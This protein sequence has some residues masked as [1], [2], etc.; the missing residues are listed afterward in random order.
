MAR[1]SSAP[2][3]PVQWK[4]RALFLRCYRREAMTTQ[5]QEV[6]SRP[7]LFDAIPGLAGRLPW[8][9][10][11]HAPTPVERCSAI[12]SWLGRDDVWM[13]RDDLISPLY[14]GNKVRRYE[15]VLADA[16]ERKAR[17]LVTAGGIA[18]TQVM[19]TAILGAHVGLPVRAV[20]FDQPLTRFA[21]RAL[22]AD[23][24]AGARLIHGG[25]YGLTALRTARAQARGTSAKSP[26][27]V[28]RRQGQAI[29]VAACGSHS[30]GSR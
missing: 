13:K 6:R 9:P 14:G 15:F 3:G 23:A 17:T 25:G 26:T 8:R 10:L 28:A 24:T 20:L 5:G 29:Q 22:L 4:P 12:A 2:R 18:S 16:L 11:A 7:A 21:Q 1:H 19:A 27:N 30:A